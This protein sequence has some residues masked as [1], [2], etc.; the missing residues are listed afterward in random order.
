MTFDHAES[1]V[2][3]PK[4]YTNTINYV[5][6]LKKDE[7]CEDRTEPDL[8]DGVVLLSVMFYHP[9]NVRK[10][11]HGFLVVASQYLTALKDKI[12]CIA[13]RIL[14]GERS[15]NPELSETLISKERNNSGFFFIDGVFYNDTRDPYNRD[16]SKVIIEWAKENASVPGLGSFKSKRMEDTKFE[17]LKI[18]L[19]YP[20]YYCH[21]G[22]CEHIFI[23][24]DMRLIHADDPPKLSA[25]P[26]KC[27]L[28]RPRRTK[29][30]VC[31][32][33]T[34]K[35][36][37]LNDVFAY[38]D[39][40]LFCAQCFDLLHYDEEGKKIHDFKA[41]HFDGSYAC[42]SECVCRICLD[43]PAPSSDPGQPNVRPILLSLLNCR[44]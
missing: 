7:Q 21:Q 4:K 14:L 42:Q 1:I 36:V 33:Y 19:G 44:N 2:K 18:R 5:H 13:D 15:L 11:D 29:C 8:E 6:H 39:P 20:Y 35:W 22:N 10:K 38:E 30:S 34:T 43:E 16:Y 9:R 31:D 23:F 3:K 41:Y 40:S 37:T 26:Q 12:E 25:Y 28:D 24:N 17:E 27:F 32:L